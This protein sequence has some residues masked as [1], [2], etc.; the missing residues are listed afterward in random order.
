MHIIHILL[1][2]ICWICIWG[3]QLDLCKN[4]HNSHIYCNAFSKCTCVFFQLQLCEKCTQFPL[5]SIY[6]LNVH[7]GLPIGILPNLHIVSPILQYICGVS[8]WDVQFGLYGKCARFLLY[9]NIFVEYT[10]GVFS[11]TCAKNAHHSSIYCNVFSECTCGFSIWSCAKNA[12]NSPYI[13][14]YVLNV[15]F[16]LPIW[17][18]QKLHVMSPNVRIYLLNVYLGC[19]I[20]IVRKRHVIHLILQHLCWIYIWGVQLD[21][22]KKDAHS[23]PIYCNVFCECTCGFQF[24]I[25]RKMNSTSPILQYTCWMYSWDCQLEFCKNCT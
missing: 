3:V 1:Q 4:A 25:V 16:G 17:I 5:Y 11:W 23:P 7:L 18:L 20:W 21:L 6:V 9:C 10:F 12:N 24:E 19:P 14:I 2:H 8:I 13:A 15:H 22:C